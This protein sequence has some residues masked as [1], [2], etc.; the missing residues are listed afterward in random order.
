MPLYER[1]KLEVFEFG[2]AAERPEQTARSSS[3]LERATGGP[4]L[5]LLLPAVL[6]ELSTSMRLVIAAA[7]PAMVPIQTS[8]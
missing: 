8:R 3:G 1:K 6:G 5:A 2:A 4:G 7:D